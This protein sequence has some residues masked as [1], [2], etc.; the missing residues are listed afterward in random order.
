MLARSF[1]L[2]KKDIERIYKKGQS[3]RQENFLIRYLVNR[4][5]HCRFSVVISKKV[6]ALATDRNA[7]KRQ[8]YQIISRSEALYKTKAQDVAII[9]KRYEGKNL[10]ESLKQV[11]ENLP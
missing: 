10:E 9:V 1:R 5:G 8:I 11:F 3:L 2:Q 7:A 4:S 6:L